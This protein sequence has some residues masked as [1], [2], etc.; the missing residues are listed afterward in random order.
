ML[1]AGIALLIALLTIG[2]QC[3]RAARMNPA[4]PLR[5]E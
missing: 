1:A 2:Y 4:Q 5:S 3:S